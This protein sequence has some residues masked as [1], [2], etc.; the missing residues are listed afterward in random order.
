LLEKNID[1]IVWYYLSLNENIFELDLKIFKKRMDMVRE[2]LMMKIF[3]PLKFK[4]YMSMGYDI[5]A[6][7]Y[8]EFDSLL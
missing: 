7:Q 3:H 6:D 5:A 4:R 2:E 8:I 1:K